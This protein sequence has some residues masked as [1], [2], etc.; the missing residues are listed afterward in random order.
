ME[1]TDT[2]LISVVDFQISR[3]GQIS[4]V[5]KIWLSGSE[6]KEKSL[7]NYNSSKRQDLKSLDT[8]LKFARRS[9]HYFYPVV[10][11]KSKIIP[12]PASTPIYTMSEM[13]N[14]FKFLRHV[15]S[16]KA[17]YLK[18]LIRVDTDISAY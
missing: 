10:I 18:P 7:A 2:I 16:G 3:K 6:I 14:L 12:D 13:D 1:P 9:K 4:A 17:V 15:H 5:R 11:K 8:S